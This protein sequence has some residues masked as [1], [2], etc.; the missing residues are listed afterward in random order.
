MKINVWR[1]VK[2]HWA[3]LRRA[4]RSNFSK[5][6]VLIFYALPILAGLLPY[7]YEFSVSKEVY[8]VSIT[9]FGIFIALLLN[10]QVAIFSIYTRKWERPDDIRLAEMKATKIAERKQLLAEVNANISYLVL[11]S[12]VALTAFLVFFSLEF[13]GSTYTA[14]SVALYC[15]F[16]LTL[17]M[18][19]KR[20]HALFQREY[21]E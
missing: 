3:T 9:F 12:C 18:I 1:I 4:G 16:L 8:N 13:I 20:A 15:H 14:A 11:V 10:M 6:D 2:D 7:L 5:V 21:I 19:V 17:L